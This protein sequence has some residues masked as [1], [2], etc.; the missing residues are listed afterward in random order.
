MKVVRALLDGEALPLAHRL[1]SWS[2]LSLMPGSHLHAVLDRH[3]R[4]S[5]VD[6]STELRQLADVQLSE[7]H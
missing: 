5:G 7:L 4:V 3:N 1:Y 2:L 6:Q